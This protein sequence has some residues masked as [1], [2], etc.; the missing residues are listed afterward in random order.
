[1]STSVGLNT[2]GDGTNRDC[3]AIYDDSARVLYRKVHATA[4]IT[5]D[6]VKSSQVITLHTNTK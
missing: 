2:K 1:M 6:Q 3:A 5:Y 4:H